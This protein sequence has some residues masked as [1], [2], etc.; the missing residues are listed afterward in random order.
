MSDIAR[1]TRPFFA[2]KRAEKTGCVYYEEEIEFAWHKGMSWQV[3]QRSSMALAQEIENKYP[4][5]A[6]RILEVSTKSTNYDIGMAL[7]AKNLLYV[8][9]KTQR[10]YPVENWFQSS[11]QFIC[12]GRTY[13]PYE[14]LLNIGSLMAKRFVNSRLDS[15]TAEQY[16]GNTLF[17]RIQGEIRYAEM[18]SFVFL[19]KRYGLEPKSAFYD[20]LYSKALNQEQNYDLARAIGEYM[21]FTDI[22]FNPKKNGNVIRYNTQARACAVFVA[23]LNRGQLETALESFESFKNCVNYE[24]GDRFESECTGQ[25]LPFC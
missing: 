20:F 5:T 23:L 4:H 25:A 10:A 24:N 12:E 18:S 8:D 14:E 11:K 19:G 21:V 16:R 13:G 9:P 7:S 22:E 1:A 17:E 2:V 3:R 15:K 6:G